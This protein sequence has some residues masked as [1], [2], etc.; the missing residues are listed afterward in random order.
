[1]RLLKGE[2]YKNEVDFIK[3]TIDEHKIV[4]FGIPWHTDTR[5]VKLWLDMKNAKYWAIEI[6][7]L[8]NEVQL[9]D[10]FYRCSGGHTLL[11]Y[12]FINGIY[13]GSRYEIL[14][15]DLKEELAKMLAE[16]YKAD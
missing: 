9:R 8:D 5:I 13:V 15:L 12:V 16:P 4:I 1:M 7:L 3:R 14:E 2:K 6:D 10:M 11:P